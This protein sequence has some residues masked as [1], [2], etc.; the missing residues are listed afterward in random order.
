MATVTGI[1]SATITTPVNGGIAGATARPYG[2][3]TYNADTNLTLEVIDQKLN[4]ESTL[5]DVFIGIADPVVYTG[6]KVS[7][8]NDFIMKLS[9]E[10]GANTAVIPIA[11]PLTGPA[12]M[13]T[14][15]A[16]RGYERD[17]TLK[18]MK[19]YYNEYSQAMVGE[20]WGKNYNDLDKFNYYA[21]IQPSLSKYFQELHGKHYRE[22]LLETYSEPLTKTGVALTQHWNP[23]WFFA[24]T[25]FGSQPSYDSTLQTFSNNLATAAAAADTGTAGVNANIDLDYLI[26]LEEY[27]RVNKR[28][29]PISMGGQMRYICVLPSKQFTKLLKNQAGQLG[30]VWVDASGLTKEEMAY[31]GT[32]GRVRSLLIV[33]DDR[34]P[35]I[36]FDTYAGDVTV[37]TEY[38]EPGND[39]SRN[40]TVYDSS[41]NMAWDIGYLLGVNAVWDWT[42]RGIH[43]ETDDDEYGKIQAQGAFTE[44][45][46]GLSFYDEDSADQDDD[47]RDNWASI[48]LA[49]TATT[50][51]ATA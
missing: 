16:Q 48:V 39:D 45:G 23:N 36:E 17:R 47:S 40:A 33:S 12:R 43:F 34:Y 32:V 38:V 46:I 8:P 27:A 21:G 51:V 50:L 22:A 13:G 15:E 3:S 4:L 19:V 24:N 31:P 28:I 42:K 5:D 37:T 41:T 2:L 49:F 30:E 29:N 9:Y 14:G 18:S 10:Q 6:D 7:V 44:R 26:N 20:K 25:E 35:T 11:D 1:G